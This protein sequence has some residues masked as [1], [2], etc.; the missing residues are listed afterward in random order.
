YDFSKVYTND[1]N[2]VYKN[3]KSLCEEG[4]IPIRPGKRNN[5]LHRWRWGLEAFKDRI[6]EIVIVER[7]GT[8][9]PC[10]KQSG[11]NA[12]KNVQNFSGGKIELRNLFDNKALFDYPK[13]VRFLQY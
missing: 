9:V 8:Y 5:I 3:N 1:E 13:G 10:F 6:K 12:P 11:F 7:N 4:Y 2:L